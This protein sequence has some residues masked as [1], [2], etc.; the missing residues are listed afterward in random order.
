M[1]RLAIALIAAG[2]VLGLGSGARGAGAEPATTDS[3]PPSGVG[4]PSS[5]LAADLAPVD[6]FEVSGLLDGIVA[7]EIGKAID[8]AATDG[9]QAL[10]LQLNSKQA[11]ISEQR[12]SELATRIRNSEVPVAIWVGP[13]GRA[14]TGSP[15]S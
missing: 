12:M 4:S 8:R 5:G 13:S 3:P 10:I 6:V 14:P 7:D 11:V 9:A 15:A 1:R 2:A